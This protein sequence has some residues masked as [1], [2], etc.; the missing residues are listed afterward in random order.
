MRDQLVKTV[1][2]K[3][4]QGDQTQAAPDAPRSCTGNCEECKAARQFDFLADGAD[5]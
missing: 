1:S 5:K 3:V 2:S 4:Q